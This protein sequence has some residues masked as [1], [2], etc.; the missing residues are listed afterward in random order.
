MQ[1]PLLL[2]QIDLCEKDDDCLYPKFLNI[3]TIQVKPVGISFYFK[4]VSRTDYYFQTSVSK[5]G[6]QKK[7]STPNKDK[8]YLITDARH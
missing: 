1:I 4:Q 5:I 6:W 2:S 8:H 7:L 3:S